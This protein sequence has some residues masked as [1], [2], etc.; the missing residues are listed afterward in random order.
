MQFASLG[1]VIILPV[2][3]LVNALLPREYRYIWL[4]LV[5]LGFYFVLDWKSGIVM[6]ASILMTYGAGL[7]L[8]KKDSSGGAGL[9][10]RAALIAAIAVSVAMLFVLRSGSI[11]GAVGISF[12]M[13]KAIGYLIDVYRGDMPA[14]RNLPK[15]SLYVS[16][17]PQIICG[18]IERAGNMLPQF[19]YPRSVDFDRMRYGLLQIIWGFVLKFFIADRLAIFVN[20]VYA[21]PADRAGTI[22]F[23]ATVFYSFEIYCDFAGYSNIA[24]GAA[25]LLGIDVMKNFDSPY[26]SGSVAEFWR[27]WHIS[28]STWLRDYVYI[29]LGGNR[30]GVARK[31]LNI[32]IVFAVSGIWHGSALTFLIWG[33]LHAVYQIIGF[34]MKPVRDAL[35]DRLHIDRGSY[36]HRFVKVV[37]TFLLVNAAWVFFRA[38]TVST[39]LTVLAKSLQFTPWVF[40]DGSLFWQGL[41]EMDM[42][43][44]LLGLG[45]LVV[46]DVIN[47]KGTDLKEKLLGEG[48][49]LRWAVMLLLIML[50][51]IC[52]IWGPGYDATS[53]IYQQF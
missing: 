8:G 23:L 5:S 16:F 19:S 15:Y 46:V 27:R 29:P 3:M 18:P 43:M 1:F 24:I 10:G 11:L 4:A 33:L 2:V 25:T 50:V 34:L 30:K 36:S 42:N 49:W 28:L 13:L 32:L 45:M 17:F 6:V 22:V 52:G 38:D 26:L 7:I 51:L 12:Y 14:E 9:G 21:S 35:V 41:D 37:F 48:A 47:Y 39:A 31:Y 20:S 44:V 40:S 53:F